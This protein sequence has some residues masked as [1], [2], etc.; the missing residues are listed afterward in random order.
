MIMQCSNCNNEIKPGAKFCAHCGTKVETEVKGTLNEPGSVDRYFKEQHTSLIEDAKILADSEMK[1]GVIW[2][3]IGMA[4]TGG[5]YL[6]A[7]DGGTYYIFWGAMIY[8]IYRLIRGFWY[9]LNPESLLKKA[10]SENK[11]K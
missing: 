4:I 9:K 6:F 3:V 10:E 1:Q 2:F 7:S 8:G 5:T 11:K